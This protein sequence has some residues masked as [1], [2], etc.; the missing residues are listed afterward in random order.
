M[1]GAS[2]GGMG[3]ARVCV[4]V[5]VVRMWG[6]GAGFV[7]EGGCLLTGVQAGLVFANVDNLA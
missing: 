1:N 5:G 7:R 6:K 4:H 2:E 3:L